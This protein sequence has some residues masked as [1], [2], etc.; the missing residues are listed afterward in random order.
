MTVRETAPGE[1][2]R[3][4][5][6]YPHAFP[7]EELRPLVS[8]LLSLED[9]VLSLGGF[10][11]EEAVAHVLFT[12]CGTGQDTRTGA[13]LGPLGVTPRLQRK[14]WGSHLVRAGLARLAEQGVRQV[15]VLGDPVYYGRFG[16]R[17]EREVSAPCPL[18]ADWAEAWQSLPLAGRGPLAPG[19]LGVPA[20]WMDPALWSG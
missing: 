9:G 10:E 11:G 12:L 5:A 8:A 2:A 7:E 19:R 16:F 3:L 20:P 15:F 18:P 13:L 17:P 4:L 14:G 6:L 1:T